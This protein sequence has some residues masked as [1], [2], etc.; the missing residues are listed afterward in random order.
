MVSDRSFDVEE[1]FSFLNENSCLFDVDLHTQAE[2][3]NMSLLEYAKKLACKATIVS[4]RSKN[5]ELQGVVIGYMHDIPKDGGSYIT[6]VIVAKKWQK[7]GIGKILLQEYF[8]KAKD[9]GI[10]FIWC[11]AFKENQAACRLYEGMG[12][13]PDIQSTEKDTMIRYIK[14]VK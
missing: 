6:Q 4:A 8:D 10:K 13:I 1:L 3:Q 11:T 5:Y 2:R 12:F 7:Q 9:A 14:S